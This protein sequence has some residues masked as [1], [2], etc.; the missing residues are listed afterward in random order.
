MTPQQRDREARAVTAIARA[1]GFGQPVAP[2]ILRRVPDVDKLVRADDATIR[3]V[4]GDA[5]VR[6][7]LR[8]GLVAGF[9]T[10][11]KQ[12][13][14]DRIRGDHLD[15]LRGWWLPV[16]SAAELDRLLR[17]PT[18]R[19]DHRRVALQRPAY[20]ATAGA[21]EVLVDRDHRSELAGYLVVERRMATA[22]LDLAHEVAADD[23]IGPSG[24]PIA[25]AGL[26]RPADG[27]DHREHPHVAWWH[28]R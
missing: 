9:E 15:W 24:P 10:V 23:G 1:C 16:L 4:L 12:A 8:A 14:M 17:T 3:R 18:P 26:D 13:V 6:G 28:G 20:P 2:L 5:D 25:A 22:V 7:S 27:V 19:S 21:A 11:W